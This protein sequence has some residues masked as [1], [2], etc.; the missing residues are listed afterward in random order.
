MSTCVDV[1]SAHLL[2]VSLLA[3]DK[4]TPDTMAVFVIYFLIK[5]LSFFH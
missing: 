3:D 4:S 1:F 2:K 5:R